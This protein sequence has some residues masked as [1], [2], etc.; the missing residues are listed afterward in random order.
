MSNNK[1]LNLL[2]KYFLKGKVIKQTIFKPYKTY[3]N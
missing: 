3:P 2:K 1:R